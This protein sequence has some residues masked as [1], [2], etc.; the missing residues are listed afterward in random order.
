VALSLTVHLEQILRGV[1]MSK[2]LIEVLR[3]LADG[4]DCYL[5]EAADR[6]EQLERELEHANGTIDDLRAQVKRQAEMLRS[7]SESIHPNFDAWWDSDK[8]STTPNT[9]KGWEE[10]CRQ[11]WYAAIDALKAQSEP[12]AWRVQVGDS[13]I[14][15]YVENE[16]DADFHGKLSGLKYKK[17]S[18]YTTPPPSAEAWLPSA[19]WTACTKLPVTVHVRAQRPGETHVST[20]EGITPIK[21]DD[22]IMRGVSGE[23]Y[24]I[25]REIFDKTY[26]IGDAP[27]PSAEDA[28]VRGFGN[29]VV[30]LRAS[31]EYWATQYNATK[32]MLNL[33]QKDSERLDW[34]ESNPRHAQVTMDDGSLTDCVFYGISC[35]TLMKLRDAIDAARGE[36]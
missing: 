8:S 2:D 23:E 6:I 24:P 16:S 27:P 11:A 36:G 21:P 1:E 26:R 13:N 12:V 10:S 25:G 31:V 35:S 19:E 4:K 22:L 32:L 28:I 17:Q 9:Y 33:A 14:W 29:E 5:W 30:A 15:G 7:H 20:R 18:L 34:L 3:E